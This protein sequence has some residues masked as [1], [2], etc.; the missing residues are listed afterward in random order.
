MPPGLSVEH[1]EA[2]FVC[3]RGSVLSIRRHVSRAAGAQWMSIR[4]QVPRAAQAQ[5]MGIRRQANEVSEYSS[6]AQ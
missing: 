2:C 3:H 6:L 5:W 1:Q 4:R